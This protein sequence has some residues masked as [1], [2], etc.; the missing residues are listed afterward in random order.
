MVNSVE[1]SIYVYG[2]FV[3]MVCIHSSGV[4]DLII[5]LV[6]VYG[7]YSLIHLQY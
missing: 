3:C 6:C 5:C 1:M 7:L 4:C 2:K